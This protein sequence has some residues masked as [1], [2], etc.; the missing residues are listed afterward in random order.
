VVDKQLQ[1]FTNDLRFP[2]TVPGQ[3]LT[4]GNYVAAYSSDDS[5]Y[6]GNNEL[7]TATPN[8]QLINLTLNNGAVVSNN[9]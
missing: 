3:S 4:V 6:L 8:S 9:G 2:R 7:M 1:S 5:W